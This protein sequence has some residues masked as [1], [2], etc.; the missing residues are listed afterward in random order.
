[1]PR[2]RFVWHVFAGLS[3]IVAATAAAAF[4]I[5]SIQLAGLADAALRDRLTD[6][7]RGLAAATLAA[8]GG[9]DHSSFEAGA[10]SLRESSR[11]D[12]RLIDGIDATGTADT[13]DTVA[14]ARRDGIASR[15]RY[16]S[17]S[18]RRS[19]EVALPVP[20]SP[21]NVILVTADAAD[22]DRTLAGWQRTLLLGCIAVTSAAAALAYALARQLARPLDGL[23]AA[24]ARLASGD[25]RADPPATDV[26]EFADLAAALVRLREQLVER[27]LTIG[28]QDTQ[29]EAVLGSMIEGVLAIDGRRRILGINRAAADLLDVEAGA[30]AGRPM[31]DVIRNPDL[32][33]FA[34]TAIDCREPVEDDLLLRGIRDRTIR[35]RGTALRD[36]SGDG[37][38]VIVLNDVTEVHRLENVRRDFVA[39]VSH[40]L[41]T[42]VASI[43][44][45]VETLL[46]GALDDH[47]DARRFLGIVSRQAD[48]LASIIEDLLALSRIEQSET[49]GTL[50]L[51]QQPLAGLLVAATDDCRPRATE[52]SIRLELTCPPML[53]VTVNGPLLE[54]AVINLVDNAIKYSEP[55]KTVWLSADADAD[56]TAIRVRD[57]GCGIAAEHL[58][59][60]FERF[61]RVDKARSRNLGGTGLGLSIVKHIVQAHAG[62]IAVE[63]T[64]GVG[65]TFTIRLPTP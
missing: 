37:G 34:L 11:I 42:P 53:M 15:S 65:T 61:Y 58:P 16:D 48:R 33:R 25:V 4:W 21:R 40:E 2:N 7:G 46:D 52:R 54:Q 63:S 27:G 30:A 38:A 28:R 39:N 36:A 64:P 29:Q 44:G 43:K 45:F 23:R 60:L 10:R 62:T 59:R 18:G 3:A 13:D 26:A 12:C 47:T 17:G 50:P 49:S 20:S 5:A 41:K 19:L 14:A 57:E 6:V 31:Q 9:I 22:S 24:A 55:G 35:L 56:G 8:G 1:M 32:R 51:D